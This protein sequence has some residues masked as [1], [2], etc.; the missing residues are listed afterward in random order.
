MKTKSLIKKL[1]FAVLAAALLATLFCFAAGAETYNGTCGAE[2]T[3]TFDTATGELVISGTGKMA[4]YSSYGAPWYSLRDYIKTVTIEDGVTSIGESAFYCCSSLTS[5]TIP[6]SVT[7]IGSYAFEYCPSLTS[8]TIPDSV[9]SIG[10][11]AFAW[12]SSLT[13]VSIPDSVTSIGSYAFEYCPSLTSVT[14]L[15]KDVSIYDDPNTFPTSAVIRGHI[16]STAQSYA[17]KF[18]RTFECIEH[19]FSDVLTYDGAAHRYVCTGCGAKKDEAAHQYTDIWQGNCDV[20]GY[21]R[22][23]FVHQGT[24]DGLKWG[25]TE[26]GDLVIAGTGDIKDYDVYPNFERAPWYSYRSTIKSVTIGNGV[27]SIGSSAF[28]GCENLES[29]ALP[30]SITSIGTYAFRDCK[31]LLSVNIPDNVTSIGDSAFAYCSAL[32]S[33]A[34][35]DGVQSIA[36]N[37]FRDCTALTSVEMG[38]NVTSIGN[39]AFYNCNKLRNIVIPDSVTSIGDYA[40][41]GCSSLTSV[42]IPDSVTSIGA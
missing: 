39:S 11:E 34:L 5:V 32:T 37:A 29:A 7:S 42:T 23:P 1:L 3:W 18:Y 9:T 25:L 28:E 35:G 38:K 41:Y 30:E 27:T 4:N 19:T 40:F 2:A 21:T 10:N 6:D 13:S 26:E 33:V 16:G 17:K 12:C 20:C 36:P 31:A 24:F 8:V 22:A 14:I 15:S